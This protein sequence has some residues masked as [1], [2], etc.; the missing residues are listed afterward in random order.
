MFLN[1]TRC[2]SNSS[3]TMWAFSSCCRLILALGDE[4]RGRAQHVT[5]GAENR[6]CRIGARQQVA[7]A[8]LGAIDSE[9]GDEG[10]FAQGCVL[11]GLLAERRRVTLD[12]EQIVG[13]LEGFAERAAVIVERLIFPLRGLAEDGTGNAAIA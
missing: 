13:D 7:N 2:C 6:Q 3:P 9:L 11:S 4:T 10:G 12:I 5:P 8:L 1:R